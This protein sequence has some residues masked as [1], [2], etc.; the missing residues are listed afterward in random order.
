MSFQRMAPTFAKGAVLIC[1]STPRQPEEVKEWNIH[2]FCD[3]NHLFLCLNIFLLY[4]SFNSESTVAKENGNKLSR[5]RTAAFFFATSSLALLCLK[6]VV[7][8]KDSK[9]FSSRNY[10]SDY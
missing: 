8:N 2:Y 10:R 4:P 1:H 9:L 3:I 6:F 7:N 5:V